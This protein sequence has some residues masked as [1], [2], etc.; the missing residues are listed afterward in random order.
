MGTVNVDAVADLVVEAIRSANAP[1]LERIAAL[2]AREVRDGAPGPRGDKGEPGTVG[3]Q[4]PEGIEGPAGRDGRDG[5]PGIPGRDGING[6]D[7]AP[8]KDGADG[9]GFD[10][11]DVVPSGERGFTIRF[12]RG[13]RVKEFTITP[14]IVLDRGVFKTG[15]TYQKGDGVTFG[16]HY[17]IAQV[18]STSD[19]PGDGVKSW[20]LAV[21]RGREGKPGRDGKD[22]RDMPVVSAGGRR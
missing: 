2:E 9:L 19:A 14:P 16:G 10:D 13:E 18:E 11:V 4:G 7:G 20:R 3:P 21:S 12:M 6:K 8:G 22:L 17:W 5:Q 1:L 15:T